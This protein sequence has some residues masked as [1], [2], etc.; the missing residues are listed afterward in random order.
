MGNS[1]QN[2]Q[3]QQEANLNANSKLQKLNKISNKK[4]IPETQSQRINYDNNNKPSNS[5]IINPKDIDGIRNKSFSE[6]SKDENFFGNEEEN[7][8]NILS[9]INK[10]FYVI[11]ITEIKNEFFIIISFSLGESFIP[12]L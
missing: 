3:S 6:S 12:F 2:S 5:K 9:K 10:N 7:N 11:L 4:N 8:P 1:K